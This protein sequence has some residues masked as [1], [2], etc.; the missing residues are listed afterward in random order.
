MLVLLFLLW[1]ILNGRVTVEIVLLGLLLVSAMALFLKRAFGYTLQTERKFWS[2]VPLLLEYALCLLGE[3]IKANCAVAWA[4]WNRKRP[5]H[6]ALVTLDMGY[7][8]TLTRYLFAN[9]IT[10][11]PGT[12]TVSIYEHSFVIHC[13]SEDLLE[14]VETGR[15]AEILGKVDARL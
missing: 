6:Q 8:H 10:L 5:L 13:L 7:E 3:V 14:G 11:T 9:S 1:V 2:L 15:I 12:I 4:I